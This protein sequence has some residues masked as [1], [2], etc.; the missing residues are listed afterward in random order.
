MTSGVSRVSIG[1]F[2][3]EGICRL[4]D[5]MSAIAS[6]QAQSPPKTPGEEPTKEIDKLTRPDGEAFNFEKALREFVKKY[7]WR[8]RRRS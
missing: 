7:V 1:F 8:A 5:E 3:P 6:G 2:D 4:Q